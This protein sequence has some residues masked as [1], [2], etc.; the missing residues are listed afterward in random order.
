[1]FTIEH[2]F[3]ATTITLVDDGERPLKEDVT[4]HAFDD[5]AVVEQ[6]DARSGQIVRVTLSTAMLRDL[7]AA[8][9]LP[10]GTYAR[11]PAS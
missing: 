3:D 7:A 4:I 6:F 2:D 10:E 8:M 1:M 9:N 5:G 11:R